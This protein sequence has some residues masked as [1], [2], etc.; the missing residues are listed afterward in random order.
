MYQR[1]L[2][3]VQ[4]NQYNFLKP[5]QFELNINY[6]SHNG[7]LRLASPVIDLIQKFFPDSIDQLS[8]EFGEIDGPQPLIVENC[9]AETFFTTC[10]NDKEEDDTHIEFRAS[11]VVIVRDEKAKE[12]VN[13]IN[14]HIRPV[15]TVF[16]AKGLEFNDVILY[17]FF[18]DSPAGSKT[19]SHEKH[20]ILSS[21]LK[22]LYV[23]ITRVRERLLIFDE[24]AELSEPIRTYWK[25]VF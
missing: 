2:N 21:E 10:I 16:D 15:F 18:T 17:N 25:D 12:R 22:H 4:N 24:D 6:R 14:K 7:I 13:K 20:Y 3:R 23:A 5:K 11:Q 9:N 8:P 19:F 1:N